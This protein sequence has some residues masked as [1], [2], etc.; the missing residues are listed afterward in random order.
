VVGGFNF[1]KTVNSWM[2]TDGFQPV[3]SG[4][5]G[6]EV[7]NQ[8]R[9]P[10]WQSFDFSLARTFHLNGRVGATLRWDVFNVF[11]T[12]N[13]GLPNRDIG[14]LSTFGTI[15]S[16]GGDARVMQLSARLAF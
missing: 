16:L 3:T 11:N 10:S 8:F 6:N 9:G 2:T 4:T 1:P 12:V 5:F 15:S 14:T 13:L 7:R